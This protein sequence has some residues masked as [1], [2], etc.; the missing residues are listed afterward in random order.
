MNK[1]STLFKVVAINL[2]CINIEFLFSNISNDYLI[3]RF[4]FHHIEAAR[5]TANSNLL[6]SILSPIFGYITDK[7][8][9]RTTNAIISK[10]LLLIAL[11]LFIVLPPLT[12]DDKSYI[13]YLPIMIYGGASALFY[14][15]VFSMIS[16][17]V[18]PSTNG[19]GFGICYSFI[20]IA[21]SLSPIF[22][23]SLTIYSKGLDAYQYT[24]S[25]L[26]VFWFV[27]VLLSVFLVVQNRLT[28]NYVLELPSIKKED[29][30]DLLGNSFKNS[31]KE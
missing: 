4:Q 16:L 31:S 25:A 23:G 11:I 29:E 26:D 5:I 2:F 7:F 21:S 10:T 15:A 1:F 17:V 14:A 24:H 9:H 19:T 12:A 28:L 20:N 6:F 22:I 18:E 8:G 3:T 30:V 13:G 27:A